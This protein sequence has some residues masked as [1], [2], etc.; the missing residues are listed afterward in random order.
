MQYYMYMWTHI[1]ACLP[2][3]RR[4]SS[5]TNPERIHVIEHVNTNLALML[6]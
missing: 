6:S 2:S 4:L 3:S 5:N 1:Q